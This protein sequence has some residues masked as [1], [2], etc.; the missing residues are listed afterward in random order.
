MLKASNDK[1]LFKFR[2]RIFFLIMIQN[3]RPTT[4]VVQGAWI[5][6][7]NTSKLSYTFSAKSKGIWCDNLFALQVGRPMQL[8]I[9]GK[10]LC[11]V[12]SYVKVSL[13]HSF[14]VWHHASANGCTETI[15]SSSTTLEKHIIIIIIES[16]ANISS[17][18]KEILATVM[19]FKIN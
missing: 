16:F 12:H 5:F 8:H 15:L 11:F 3:T 14:C 6:Y 10:T 1:Y 2:I 19:L 13:L 4:A 18:R 7:N 17:V 9:D